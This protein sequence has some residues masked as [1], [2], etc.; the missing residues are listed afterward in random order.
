M[1]E[2]ISRELARLEAAG[3][4]TA[5]DHRPVHGEF[6][7]GSIQR[8]PSP[9]EQPVTAGDVASNLDDAWSRLKRTI[10]PE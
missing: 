2:S 7:F 4:V 8:E 1:A 9:G 3:R 6:D 10:N 5:H